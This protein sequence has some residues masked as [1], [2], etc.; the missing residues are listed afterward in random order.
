MGSCY[1]QR[2]SISVTPLSQSGSNEVTND[3][4]ASCEYNHISLIRNYNKPILERL[5]M[6]NN[7]K[8]MKLNVN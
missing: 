4:E 6:K 3:I 7:M 1:G 5:I 2:Q 8:K